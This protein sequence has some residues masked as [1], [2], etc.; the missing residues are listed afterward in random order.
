MSL[1]LTPN[2]SSEIVLSSSLTL[3]EEQNVKVLVEL[4]W[5]P[6][7]SASSFFPLSFSPFR[8]EH[9]PG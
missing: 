4:S 2:R 5:L 9:D 8:V 7:D 6:D 1:P 3:G